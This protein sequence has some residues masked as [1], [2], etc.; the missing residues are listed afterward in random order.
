MSRNQELNALIHRA[1]LTTEELAELLDLPLEEIERWIRGGA[2]P[3][4]SIFHF[5]DSYVELKSISDG[6]SCPLPR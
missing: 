2:T 4:D 3:P 6:V 5:L 1:D